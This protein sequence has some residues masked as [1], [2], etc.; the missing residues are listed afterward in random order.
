MAIAL[1]GYAP[2]VGTALLVNLPYSVYFL[3]RSVRDGA[4]S[5][6]GVASAL[7]LALPALVL[8]LAALYAALA[9]AASG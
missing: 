8:I 1:G 3:R 2:G 4:V 6:N 7:A 5:R 9:P